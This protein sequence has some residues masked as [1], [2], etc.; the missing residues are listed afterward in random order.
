LDRLFERV[1]SMPPDAVESREEAV[2]VD[3]LAFILSA[4][5]FPAGSDGLDARALGHI[6]IERRDL[7]AVPNFS[8]V[9]VVGCLARGAEGEWLVSRASA[10]TRTKDPAA[11][12]GDELAH[13]AASP[14]GT[15]TFRLLDVYP[16]PDNLLGHLV[17]AKG[18]L[19]AG[20]VNSVNVTAIASLA[21]ACPD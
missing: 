13:A 17:E 16:S 4:N 19:I 15:Q 11:S 9:Q 10:P 12:T 18:F 5:G 14:R 3:L 20:P 1:Q 7:D 2:S 21:S 6:I 8:L